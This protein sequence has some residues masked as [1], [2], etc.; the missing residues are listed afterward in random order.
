MTAVLQEEKSRAQ[1][2]AAAPKH[3]PAAKAAL[4]AALLTGGQDP[5]YAHG[6][7]MALVANGVQVDVI[8]SDAIDSPQ[9]HSTP[10]LRF[11]NSVGDTQEGNPAARIK[12][13]LLSYARLMHYAATSKAGVLHI[14]WNNKIQF[15]DRTLLMLYYKALGKKIVLT[16]HNVN[17]ERRDSKDSPWNRFTLRTQY[18]LAGHIFVH[19]KKMKDEL[20]TQFHVPGRAVTV[21]PYGVNNAVPQSALTP[22]EARKRLGMAEDEKV[23]LFFGAIK[24]YK[25]LEYLVA[26]F[27]KLASRNP[28]LRLVI[29]G[30]RK[31]G[32]EKYWSAIKQ[33]IDAGPNHERILQK[34]EFIPDA[35]TE[36]YF[37]AA[38]VAV[39]PYTEIFQSGILFLAYSF[40]LPVIATDVGSFREDIIEG[41]TGF[42]CRP[43]DANALAEA[44]EKYFA[45]D[46]FR[47]LP[48]RRREIRDDTFAQHSW[49]AVG[50]ISRQVYEG[51]L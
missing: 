36:L 44:I 34:I 37:Q 43:R 24:I 16:A 2:S 33:A 51:L 18:A 4:Q 15:F 19:T 10:G 31:K 39:L 12:R 45:S 32:H 3:P 46:L 14:L 49:E 26:A 8:G 28:G 47:N 40:G 25:G 17:A 5:H 29:A 6:L 1:G 38:D 23:I 27:Q 22:A 30:E 7:A 21:I 20:Q 41:R 42:L 9:M 50:E 48:L 11:F 35:E 13:V